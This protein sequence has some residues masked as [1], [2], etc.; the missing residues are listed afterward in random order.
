MRPVSEWVVVEMIEYRGYSICVE[1]LDQWYGYV[2]LP[3]SKLIAKG[4]VMTASL[5]QGRETVVD[6]AKQFIDDEYL[7][8]VPGLR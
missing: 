4:G 5:S 8:G 6:R 1:C 7:F 3:E 2:H